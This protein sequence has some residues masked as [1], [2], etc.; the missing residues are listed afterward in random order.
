MFLL[1]QVCEPLDAV[2]E[3]Q[4]ILKAEGLVV[5]NP[6]TGVPIAH[7]AQKMV[8]DNRDQLL[9]FLKALG[10]AVDINEVI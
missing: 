1:G 9:R 5:V 7:P 2:R 10:L 4:A 8:K 6:K 3:A